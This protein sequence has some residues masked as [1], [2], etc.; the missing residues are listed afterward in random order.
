MFPTGAKAGLPWGGPLSQLRSRRGPLAGPA[1]TAWRAWPGCAAP[2][3]R[4]TFFLPSVASPNFLRLALRA[5]SVVRLG[6]SLGGT[7]RGWKGAV[8]CPPSDPEVA[9]GA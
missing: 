3:L 2:R 7:A 6:A 9:G 5:F 8:A 1:A 4:P